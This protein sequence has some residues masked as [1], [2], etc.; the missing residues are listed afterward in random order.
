MVSLERALVNPPLLRLDAR[1]LCNMA[2]WGSLLN[3]YCWAA[4]PILY[5]LLLEDLQTSTILIWKRRA[6]QSSLQWESSMHRTKG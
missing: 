5:I 2:Q 4:A 6:L 1:P 3:C